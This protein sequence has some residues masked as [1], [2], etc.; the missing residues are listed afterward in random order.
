MAFGLGSFVFLKFG[1]KILDL[2]RAFT[3]GDH[4]CVRGPHHDE[5]L[6]TDGRNQSV[7]AVNYTIVGVMLNAEPCT[8]LLS[9]S[10]GRTS[11]SA[12]Q[13]PTSDDRKRS[14]NDSGT[15][16][17]FHS[18]IIDRYLSLAKLSASECQT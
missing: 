1:D 3:G 7:V 2:L 4:D 16:S 15:I 9:V 11:A 6:Y 8:I 13:L 10:A 14:S 17:F 18:S 5:I 12:S